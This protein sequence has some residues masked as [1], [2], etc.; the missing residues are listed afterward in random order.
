MVT[1][2]VVEEGDVDVDDYGS[3]HDEGLVVPLAI[4]DHNNTN[5]NNPIPSRNTKKLMSAGIIGMTATVASSALLFLSIMDSSGQAQTEESFLLH[6]SGP[7]SK[8]VP[9]SGPWPAGSFSLGD[10]DDVDMPFKTC[11][12]NKNGAPVDYC[13]SHSYIDGWGNWQPCTPQG[14]GEEW[15]FDIDHSIGDGLG[16]VIFQGLGTCGTGCTEFS[17]DVPH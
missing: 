9:A 8:C 5:S 2:V 10:D 13:W 15:A 12:K 14:F 1:L 11:F 4:T 3:T 17:K 16:T 7:Y 6:D